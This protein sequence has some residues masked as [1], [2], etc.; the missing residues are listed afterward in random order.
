[1]RQTL[2]IDTVLQQIVE[3][4]QKSPNLVLEAPPGAG[5]TTRV[6][7]ALLALEGEVL[8]LEPRRLAARM[9]ARRVAEELGER[10]G[11]TV[12]YQVRFEE[13]SGPK[14]RL[15]FLTEGVLTRR[16]LKDREL[17]GVGTVILDEFHERHLDGDLAL[18]LLRRLQKQKRP[19]LRI[20][21]MSATLDA[22]PIAE[23]LEAPIIRSEGKLYP[24]DI[25]YRPGSVESGLEW[26]KADGDVLVFLP[27]AREIRDTMRETE[28]ILRKRGMI[29]LPL[30]G[31]LS[32]EEQDRAVMPA[33]QPKVIFSTNVAES[34]LTIEGVRAVIDSGTARVAMDDPWTGLPSLKVTKISQAS[35]IQ[36]AGRAARTAPGQVIRLYSLDDYHRRPAQDQPEILRR[37]LSQ[38]LLA[39]Q[40]MKIDPEELDWIDTPASNALDSARNLLGMLKADEK[41]IRYPVHPRLARLIEDAGREGARQAAHLLRDERINK[42]SSAKGSVDA[43]LAL[44]RAFP[45]RVAK[46]L[47]DD[48]FLLATGGSAKGREIHADWIV[49]LDIENRF[50]RN[51]SGIEPDWLLDEFPDRITEREILDWN[52]QAERVD[53]V[54][55]LEFERL[56]IIEE[57]SAPQDASGLLTEKALEAGIERFT[58]VEELAQIR[59]RA[60][61]AGEPITDEELKNAFQQHCFGARSFQEISGF[62][63]A[64]LRPQI[65]QKSPRTLR[66]PSGRNA[67]IT[68]ISGQPPFVASRMQDFF[69]MRE[70]PRINGQ[71]LV[72]HLLAPSQRPVQITQDLA[73]FWERH[74]PSIRKELMRKYPRHK[75]PEDPFSIVSESAKPDADRRHPR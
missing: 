40:S 14:T 63:A 70:T 72:V 13:I 31:D 66:L 21:V 65:D 59:A 33:S 2:P 6:P 17:R 45:D 73:G 30:Y 48:E 9:A 51:W 37:E 15:R 11:E 32:P 28:G 27:G 19:D 39:L 61:F 52:R 69:G 44:L 34:S 71:P 12:G 36:R 38:L 1:M 50:I 43:P 22:A 56:A 74:Y 16:L 24:L 64:I 62:S 35:A 29:G 47:R 10:I 5:K 18:A 55:R 68:Y 4:L 60:E 7:A 46:R 54:R 3:S 75:W 58:D 26:M 20:V 25:H 41:L 49:V 53:A 42:L 8:V 67:K 57:R 23:A